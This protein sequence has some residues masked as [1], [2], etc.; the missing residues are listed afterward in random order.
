[1][2]RTLHRILAAAAG[3]LTLASAVA[4]LS[5]ACT[6]SAYIGTNPSSGPP[7][8][9]VVVSGQGFVPRTVQ[10]TVNGAVVATATGPSFS[11]PVKVPA[12]AS[13]VVYFG[14]T[15]RS[16]EGAVLGGASRAFR[17]TAPAVAAPGGSPAATPQRSALTTSGQSEA[18]RE[19]AV[20]R[21]GAGHSPAAGPGE[22]GAAAGGAVRA[23]SRAGAPRGLAGPAGESGS[24]STAGAPSARGTSA[25]AEARGAPVRSP[26]AR[27]ASA[28]LWS[29]FRGTRAGE[30]LTGAR[31][32][33]EGPGFALLP[34]AALLT[35][36]LLS[37]AGGLAVATTRSR[38]TRS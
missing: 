16:A 7:G 4:A 3:M 33:A 17:V 12:T 26:S 5:W 13:G 8:S 28:D 23:P 2:K 38:R 37:L 29:G 19:R 14:A 25:A 15:S 27:S 20:G 18:A 24:G 22:G 31:G 9:T 32:P 11:V 10:I 1:M 36:G 34:G 30:T 35:L 6:P 21:G